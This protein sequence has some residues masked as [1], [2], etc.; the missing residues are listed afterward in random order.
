[1]LV[2]SIFGSSFG[3]DTLSGDELTD[4]SNIQYRASMLYHLP[5]G[6]LNNTIYDVSE[7]NGNATISGTYSDNNWIKN[8][9]MT[10]NKYNGV[11][12]V[13]YQNTVNYVPYSIVDNTPL[14]PDN[15]PVINA[16]EK[17]INY[18]ASYWNKTYIVINNNKIIK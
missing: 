8:D 4:F 16:A 14:Y 18:P 10:F 1:M 12:K 3:L 9:T 17:T 2:G 7:I 15:S 6:S 13:K 5:Y 11:T